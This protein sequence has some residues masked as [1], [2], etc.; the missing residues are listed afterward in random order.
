MQ[1]A[2]SQILLRRLQRVNEEV[3]ELKTAIDAR[4][5]T[6]Q[7]LEQK[8]QFLEHRVAGLIKERNEGFHGTRAR[9]KKDREE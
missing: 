5:R 3:V 6:I 1:Q 4:D 7:D 2:L 9:L 8:T